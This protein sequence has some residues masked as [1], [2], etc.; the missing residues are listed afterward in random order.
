MDGTGSVK[1]M[2][3]NHIPPLGQE[4]RLSACN[5]SKPTC[6]PKARRLRTT[7]KE[8]KLMTHRLLAL[9]CCSSDSESE[10]G[11]HAEYLIPDVPEGVESRRQ[12]AQD[13]VPVGQELGVSARDVP[14]TMQ[15]LSYQY[16]MLGLCLMELKKAETLSNCS[17]TGQSTLNQSE[18]DPDV[19]R[20]SERERK[21][22]ERFMYD[23][24]GEPTKCVLVS[25]GCT[26]HSVL[27]SQALCMTSVKSPNLCYVH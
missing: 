9:S 23:I 19:V 8:N 18:G 1:V 6:S 26:V 13:I 20:R 25:N 22:A 2:H 21:P 16:R 7:K 12:S 17:S 24:L 5:D 4:V 11:N 10:Y 27:S 14:V 15:L 3:C